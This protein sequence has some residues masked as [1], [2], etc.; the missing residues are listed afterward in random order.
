[1]QAVI[2]SVYHVLKEIQ[3]EKKCNL[4]EKLGFDGDLDSLFKRV[5]PTLE[6]ASANQCEDIISAAKRLI[7]EGAIGKFSRKSN[8]GDQLVSVQELNN[9]ACAF[10][11]NDTVLFNDRAMELIANAVPSARNK[12]MVLSILE[13]HG[14]LVGSRV[15]EAAYG[16]KLVVHTS[17]ET[18]EN[19]YLYQVKINIPSQT[20]KN[21]VMHYDGPVF[22]LGKDSDGQSIQWYFDDPNH[23]NKHMLITGKSGSGKSFLLQELVLQASKQGIMTIVIHLQGDVR[24]DILEIA[25]RVDLREI[26]PDVWD[27]DWEHDRKEI[28]S[29]FKRSL[30][31]T[32]SQTVKLM[33]YCEEYYQKCEE[34]GECPTLAGFV[35]SVSV[36]MKKSKHTSLPMATKIKNIADSELFRDSA[37]DWGANR[38]K[39]IVLDFSSMSE[40]ENIRKIQTEALLWDVYR[41]KEKHKNEPV[42]LVVDEFHTLE[43]AKTSMLGKILSEGRKYGWS[44]WL[45]T[46]LLNQKG[47]EVLK[48][49]VDQASMQI[50]FNQGAEGNRNVA[51]RIAVDPKEREQTRILMGS[52]QKRQFLIKQDAEEPRVGLGIILKETISEVEV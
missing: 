48:Q 18:K 34:Q 17:D 6:E 41:Y 31:L 3:K 5:L 40:E 25:E 44:M 29:L 15:N 24:K 30:Q 13:K 42:V 50:F 43:V 27:V 7:E 23:A 8:V 26:K 39:T 2:S 20:K 14:K 46:Q 10:L 21:S 1:M 4:D 12:S 16:N 49:F 45:G 38:K 22:D 37:I 51:K 32:E 9:E 35:K 11:E 36:I 33:H 47:G 52:L 28:T 19:C